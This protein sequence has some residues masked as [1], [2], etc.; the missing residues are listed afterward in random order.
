M[1]SEQVIESLTGAQ[2]RDDRWAFRSLLE[3]SATVVAVT[4]HS[5]VVIYVS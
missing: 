4:D 2:P 3:Q 5:G 1:A